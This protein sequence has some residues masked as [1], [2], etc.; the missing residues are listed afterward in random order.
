MRINMMPPKP[1]YEG[2]THE[3][4][5]AVRMS[6]LEALRRSVMSCLLWEDTFYEDGEEIGARIARLAGEVEPRI[7]A[8]MAVEARIGFKLRHVPLL[9]LAVL[10]RTGAGSRIV[11]D[12]IEAVVQRADE[13]AE[14]LAIYAKLNGVELSALKPKLSN[15][16][17]KGLGAA[18]RKFDSYQLAKYDREGTVRLR[19][20]LFLVHPK[21]KDAEQQLLWDALARGTIPPPDTWE[22]AL[23]SGAD[24]GET[25]TRLLQEGKLGYLALLRNLRN[26]EGAGVD[27]GLILD[28]LD[29]RKGADRVLPF[30]YVAAARAA[31]SFTHVLDV[32]LNKSLDGLE[33]LQG[34]TVV[35]VDVSSSMTDKL[36]MKSDL[37]RA[38][39]AATLAAII[40]GRD[41][42]T[43]LFNDK[44]WE[45]P[46]AKGL[47]GIEAIT[48]K[49]AG[50]T[51]VGEA[52]Q[53]VTDKVR[54]ATRL[55]VITDEQSH[56]RVTRPVGFDLAYMINVAS[57]QHGVGYKPNGWLHLD[58]FSENVL[59]FI[60]ANEGNIR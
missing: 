49:V 1:V 43:F 6:N 11:R 53:F 37:Q 46:R 39:A 38:D 17:R 55:I 48:S 31:P 54:Q 14:F 7:L 24:K 52:V 30:R 12:T 29:A 18:F 35:L 16:V 21:P 2:M 3:G 9:L 40:P 47:T 60:A 27:R 4:G 10:C 33:P 56:D 23:S 50:G 45:I 44:C 57:N 58:G 19:D 13:L 20:A 26:M 32:A 5:P 36:S 22:V 28:A 8:A 15:Q 59:R 41:V 25:F 42:R 34:S 51:R